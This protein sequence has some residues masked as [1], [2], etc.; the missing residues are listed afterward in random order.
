MVKNTGETV[1]IIGGVTS[2]VIVMPVKRADR[3]AQS[4][5]HFKFL[6]MSI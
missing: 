4:M 5:S 3:M 6:M 1:K 2:A